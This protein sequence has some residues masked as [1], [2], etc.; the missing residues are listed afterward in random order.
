MNPPR[1][2]SSIVRE[3]RVQKQLSMRETSKRVGC[4]EATLFRIEHGK[5]LNPERR[6]L[7]RLAETLDIDAAT[8]LDINVS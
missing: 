4:T 1:T 5:V 3:A 7:K 6:I 8:L 2:L